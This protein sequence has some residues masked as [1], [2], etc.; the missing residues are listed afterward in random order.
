MGGRCRYAA[1]AQACSSRCAAALR[2]TDW[3]ASGGL[4]IML[5]SSVITQNAKY[6][7]LSILL[8]RIGVASHCDDSVS[9][10]AGTTHTSTSARIGC[11][12]ALRA[13]SRRTA[14][15]VR[16]EQGLL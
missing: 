4:A 10:A 7:A 8:I 1:R 14:R 9:A 13:Q 12:C 5:P 16:S 2:A 15:S 11:Y 3:L 6:F